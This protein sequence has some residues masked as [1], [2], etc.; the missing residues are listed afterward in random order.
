MNRLCHSLSVWPLE[1]QD[2]GRGAP[3]I[4]ERVGLVTRQDL[5]LW[6]SVNDT[7]KGPDDRDS[8][9]QPPRGTSLQHSVP[10]GNL[11]MRDP[12]VRRQLVTETPSRGQVHS[13]TS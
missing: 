5:N 1:T 6:G 12:R 13:C 4:S 8:G 11:T 2:L 3:T 7:P 9:S 10:M